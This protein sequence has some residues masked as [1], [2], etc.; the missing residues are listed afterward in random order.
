MPEVIRNTELVRYME[1][2]SMSLSP[3]GHYSLAVPAYLQVTSP[4]RRYN[5]IIAHYQIKAHLKKQSIPFARQV[6]AIFSPFLFFS[7]VL[8]CFF[9]L[10]S[11]TL[12]AWDL[13][14]GTDSL[15]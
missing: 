7:F 14:I 10:D 1:P 12:C 9:Y 13:L 4:I 6:Y 8:F 11:F 5:D 2:A 15:R 3:L